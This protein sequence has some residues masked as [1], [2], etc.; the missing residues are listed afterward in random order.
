M[1]DVDE[2]DVGDEQESCSGH[3]NT[4]QDGDN[5]K[6]MCSGHQNTS[7]DGSTREERVGVIIFE[8]I[9]TPWSRG[10]MAWS[11]DISGDDASPNS[12]NSRGSVEYNESHLVCYLLCFI[13]V[14]F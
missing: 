13:F 6:M 12:I 3:Q 5:R 11:Y 10:H 14:M 7:C 9:Y 8:G 4:T 1:V 2:E